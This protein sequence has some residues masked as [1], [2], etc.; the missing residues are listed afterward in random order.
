MSTVDRN[1]MFIAV[2]T[3]MRKK[4]VLKFD[5]SLLKEKAFVNFVLLSLVALELIVKF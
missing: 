5:V 1:K 4:S 2:N 3:G